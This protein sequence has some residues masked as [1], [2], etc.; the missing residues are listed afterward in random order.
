MVVP[1][2]W[3]GAA[4]AILSNPG[5]VVVL[6]ATDS[7]KSTFCSY[8]T[9]KGIDTGIRTAL[10]D[11]DVGQSRVGPPGCIGWAWAGPQGIGAEE[12]LW[13]VGSF[14][15]S[16]HLSEC[17]VGTFGW[18]CRRFRPGRGWWWWIRPGW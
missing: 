18:S 17:I 1:D 12:D 3:R 16:G 13:F 4:E 5:V 8:L 9:G 11:A 10:V 2:D 6:G 7:G 14:S 15:P